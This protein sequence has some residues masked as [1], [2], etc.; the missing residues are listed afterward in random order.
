MSDVWTVA[1]KDKFFEKGS[2]TWRDLQNIYHAK[3]RKNVLDFAQFLE[4][5]PTISLYF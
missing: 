4:I 3:G 1:G 5:L 2:V